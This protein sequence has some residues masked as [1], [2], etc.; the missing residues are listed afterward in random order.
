MWLL[1]LDKIPRPERSGVL[2][3]ILA[4]YTLFNM[5]TV[6]GVD[7]SCWLTRWCSP[8]VESSASRWIFSPREKIVYLAPSRKH[9]RSKQIPASCF[10]HWDRYDD[11]GKLMEH[12]PEIEETC[13]LRKEEES[14]EKANGW[15]LDETY[16]RW[17]VHCSTDPRFYPSKAYAD[18]DIP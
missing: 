15:S 11:N 9:L 12:L 4:L 18:L 2:G 10:C 6:V 13:R 16:V 7:D 3:A 5:V 1:P 8:A 17:K 14:F